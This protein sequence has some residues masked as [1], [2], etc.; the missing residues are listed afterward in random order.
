MAWLGVGL[1]AGLYLEPGPSGSEG[2]TR[3]FES[4]RLRKEMEGSCYKSSSN[5]NLV[6][7]RIWW[8]H[9]VEMKVGI[10]SPF[11]MQF[12]VV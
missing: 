11:K 3:L 10:R 1:A 5:K 4:R 7:I 2:S 12:L 9:K 6:F 8:L